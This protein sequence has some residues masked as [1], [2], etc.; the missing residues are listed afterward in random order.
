M[1]TAEVLWKAR[2]LVQGGWSPT[3]SRDSAGGMCGPDDEG[4][5]K[6]CL[7]D[8]CLTAAKGDLV[9]THAAMRAVGKPL[10]LLTG[11]Q[12]GDWEA[13]ATRDDVLDQLARAAKRAE[14]QEAA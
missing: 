2:A 9:A 11:M 14:A 1:R 8:A 4:I 12:L 5:E 13:E 6:F 3:V 10:H 7:L